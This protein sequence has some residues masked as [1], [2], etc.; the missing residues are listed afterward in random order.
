MD[1]KYLAWLRKLIADGKE[2]LFYKSKEWLRKRAE[3]LELDHHECQRCKKLGHYTKATTVHHV[4]HLKQR[5]D[6]ALSVYDGKERQLISLCAAC[7][8]TEHGHRHETKPPLTP[9]RW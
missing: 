3:V 7:H 6:L 8:E 2:I 5:P 9:E 1:G 4:K